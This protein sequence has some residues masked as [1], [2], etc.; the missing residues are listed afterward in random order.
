MIAPRSVGKRSDMSASR[1]M[2]AGVAPA[3][4]N[5]PPAA[6]IPAAIARSGWVVA[7]GAVVLTVALWLVFGTLAGSAA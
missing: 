1:P 2:A 5:R 6:T 4:T 7:I 3:S